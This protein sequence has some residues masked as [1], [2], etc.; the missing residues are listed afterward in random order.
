MGCEPLFDNDLLKLIF[1]VRFFY[2]L[3][4]RRYLFVP[5]RILSPAQ[6]MFAEQELVGVVMM[7]G[8]VVHD[9]TVIKLSGSLNS[10]LAA[11]D[12]GLCFDQ[13]AFFYLGCADNSMIVVQV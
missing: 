4:K 12:I 6:D 3:S 2:L 8:G 1:S 11:G 10:H 5:A 13:A 7:H 9:D